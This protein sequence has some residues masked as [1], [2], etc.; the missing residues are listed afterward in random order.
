MLFLSNTIS[1]RIKCHPSM[2]DNEVRWIQPSLEVGR[3]V[4]NTV[5]WPSGAW[6]LATN[7]QETIRRCTKARPSRIQPFRREYLNWLHWE[8]MEKF[9]SK[10]RWSPVSTG[11][12]RVERTKEWKQLEVRRRERDNAPI[13][14]RGCLVRLKGGL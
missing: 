13:L 12:K 7:S 2:F 3:S 1:L 4:G 8:T 11:R 9:N 6:S 14:G 5:S 10:P